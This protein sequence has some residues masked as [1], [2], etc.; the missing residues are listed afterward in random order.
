MNGR[1]AVPVAVIV[2]NFNSAAYLA[3][4]LDALSHQTF[5]AFRTIVVD[6]ASTD[7]SDATA[8]EREEVEFI[9]AGRNTGFA[10]GNNLGLR[11]ADGAQWVVLLNPDAFPSPDW[12]ERLLAAAATEPQFAFF[13]SRML[14]AEAPEVLDGTGDVH[15]V[16]GLSW[17]RD[18]GVP[19]RLGVATG[20]EIFG[21]CAAAAMYARQAVDEAG[22]FD[23]RYFCY[24]E[25]IDLAFRLRLLGYRCRYVPDAIVWHV[26]SGI[27]GRRSDFAT[28]HGQRNMVW[29]FVK[30]MTGVT[31]WL[32][33][34]LHLAA[35][36]A[37]IAVCAA[38][39][40][41]GVVLRAKRDAICGVA[42]AWRA[43]AEI[44]KSRRVPP[45]KI[46]R[47]LARGWLALMRRG[48]PAG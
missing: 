43:R 19:A 31:F 38:R 26:S 5:R 9:G 16:S 10:A 1:V 7:G 44:Q 4:C 12:L 32:Y 47:V 3:R 46:L 34:P 17:R 14:L 23:E 21:P 45:A 48:G 36:V 39:G 29:T 41:L 2:V 15:H 24:H 25:D 20:G 28:Y 11:H 8:R 22:G 37:A 18:H 13:G 6:N 27:A 30:D 35:N 42:D 40:Q 33:L